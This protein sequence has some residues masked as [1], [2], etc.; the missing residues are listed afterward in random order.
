[1]S[2]HRVTV[3]DPERLTAR[4]FDS[5]TRT[6]GCRMEAYREGDN[7]VV[8][9]DLPGVDPA[10]IDVA[11][12]RESMTIRAERKHSEDGS[13]GDETGPGQ[14]AA[15]ASREIPLSDTLDT[16]HIQARHNDG[17]LTLTIPV[18]PADRGNPAPPL[19]QAA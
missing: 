9:I 13:A 14:P 17:V 15:V 12:D 1:M 3:R 6:S 18:V 4:V 8:D 7:F 10:S 2:L 16:N 19:A 11:V 5:A